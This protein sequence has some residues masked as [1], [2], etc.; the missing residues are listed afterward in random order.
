MRGC[1]EASGA[2]EDKLCIS[3]AIGTF[4]SIRVGGLVRRL[5]GVL[6]N[7]KA[8]SHNKGQRKYIAPN[9]KINPL[10]G[11]VIASNIGIDGSHENAISNPTDVQSVPIGSGKIDLA[12]Q[13]RHE[14]VAFEYKLRHPKGQSQTSIK[15]SGFVFDK[16]IVLKKQSQTAK[17]QY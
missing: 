14:Q 6:G 5:N 2:R 11:G 1:Q 17:N 7:V 12:T 9:F 4:V 16:S 15:Q 3:R 8:R 10:L 13:H